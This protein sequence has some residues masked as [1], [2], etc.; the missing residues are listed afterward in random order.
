MSSWKEARPAGP[1][2]WTTEN[3]TW[4]SAMGLCHSA[5]GAEAKGRLVG[6]PPPERTT[7]PRATTHMRSEPTM[8]NH[9]ATA[10]Q[11]PRTTV[12]RANRRSATT[13]GTDIT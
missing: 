10:S 7:S 4:A 11:S 13:S 5:C 6:T 12:A 8:T 1:S 9:A 2:P 3:S